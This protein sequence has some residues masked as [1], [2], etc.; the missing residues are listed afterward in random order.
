[1][2]TTELSKISAIQS[3]I[4]SDVAALAKDMSKYTH[5]QDEMKVLLEKLL[6]EMKTKN[7]A[8]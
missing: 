3:G 7:S 2:S 5:G 1:S 4:V 8:S 6:L